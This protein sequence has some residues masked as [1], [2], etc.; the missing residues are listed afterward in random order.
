MHKMLLKHDPE[1]GVWGDCHRTA[2]AALLDLHPSEVP[3]FYEQGPVKPSA[4]VEDDINRWLGNNYGLRQVHIGFPGETPLADV[5]GT[6]EAFNPGFMF[7]LGGTS[8]RGCGHSVLCR[9]G[10]IHFDPSTDDTGI[11]GPM[12]DGLWWVTFLAHAK[13]SQL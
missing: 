4:D 2:I 13:A 9:F 11:V 3:H 10:K 8:S 6:M 7:L 5:L 12:E 1:N